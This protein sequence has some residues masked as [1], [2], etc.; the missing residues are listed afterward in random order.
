MR[1]S[2]RNSGWS[3]PDFGELG[4]AACGELTTGSRAAAVAVLLCVSAVARA[5]GGL[6]GDENLIA[7]P[8]I[9]AGDIVT[10]VI[11]PAGNAGEKREGA[12]A[13]PVQTA[14][15][16]VKRLPNGNLVLEARV[17]LGRGY[18]LIGGEAARSDL[19]TNRTVDVSRLANLAVVARDLEADTLSELTRS[20]ARG[21]C[22]IGKRPFASGGAVRKR[23]K[24]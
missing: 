20:L 3:L 13:V 5:G 19:G 18:V 15:R 21:A 23:V 14:A 16:V 11:A 7:D 6:W 8:R 17:R 4:S 1:N 12:P 24:E 22:G 9:E 10:I 2:G